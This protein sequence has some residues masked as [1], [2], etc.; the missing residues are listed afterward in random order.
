MPDLDELRS[1]VRT[2][3]RK[4]DAAYRNA[5]KKRG[6]LISVVANIAR[7][8]DRLESVAGGAPATRD[9]GLLD[10]V[11]DLLVYGLKYETYLA[12][13]DL[14][15]AE[16]LFGASA[17]AAPFSDRPLGFEE[18]LSRV[19]LSPVGGAGPAPLP[20]AVQDVVAAF[21]SLE[22][23]F[24]GLAVTEEPVQRLRRAQDL[25]EASVRLLAAVEAQHPAALS[26]FVDSERRMPGDA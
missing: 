24:S 19:D 16:V 22:A 8:V 1:A 7:K 17:I 18:L 3:H 26:A 25:V 11:V 6:E 20:I 12:D 9:E 15:V 14:S 10:T 21:S 4:K 13:L 2:L 23:C 5:W